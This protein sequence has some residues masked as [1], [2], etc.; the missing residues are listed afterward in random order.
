MTLIHINRQQEGAA[1]GY[2]APIPVPQQHGVR[3]S[4]MALWEVS[5]LAQRCAGEKIR[6]LECLVR[7]GTTVW[8]RK[9]KTQV[10][11]PKMVDDWKAVVV[12]L[13]TAHGKDAVDAAE[14]RMDEL[15]A[16]MLTAPVA[17]LREFYDGLSKALRSDDAVPFFVWSMFNAWGEVIV[18]PSKDDEKIIRLRRKLAR[19]VAVMVEKDIQP[20]I[21]AAVVGALMWRDPETLETIK[22]DLEAGA[23][24][25][26][27]GKESCLFLVT[28][29]RGGG[30]HQVML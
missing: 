1:P 27:R 21:T 23:K 12:T 5:R 13:C 17:Q 11:I 6:N 24:P 28:R 10:D 3:D 30:E 14:Y 18:R 4:T 15:L 20:D 26:L 2:D 25:R 19:E 16:P 7:Y 8:S 22:A 9:R 29:P